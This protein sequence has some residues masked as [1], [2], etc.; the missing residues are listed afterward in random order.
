MPNLTFFVELEAA[1][2]DELLTESVL[3]DLQAIKAGVSIGLLDLSERRAQAIRRLNEAGVPVTAWLLL[4]RDQ[5]YWFNA[6]NAEAALERYSA[7]R[8]WTEQYGLKWAAVGLDF[9]MD[10]HEMEDLMNS[11]G[12]TIGRMALRA[13]DPRPVRSAQRLY[14]ALVS[15]IRADGLRVESY[16]LPPVI[17]ERWAGS[18]WLRRFL[19]LVDVRTDR[20]VPMLYTSYFRNRVGLNRSVLG[21]AILASYALKA[22]AIGVGSAGGGVEIPGNSGLNQPLTWD[23]LARDLRLAYA[24]GKS[25]I[26]I[27]S[28]EGCVRQ[29]FLTRLKTLAWDAPVILPEDGA[30]FVD[31]WRGT[32]RG[33]LWMIAHAWMFLLGGLAVAGGVLGV[34]QM[35]SKKA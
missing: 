8:G 14:R 17:D 27:F 28:L 25:D 18:S 15:Q 9:E 26:Y 23:E 7:F 12:R 21:P 2:L 11:T 33:G 24:Y 3:A 29:G 4:G 20:E 6:G 30:R 16:I 32:L 10:I 35:L 19:R 5:G 31:G 34:R 1:D 22:D 13:F